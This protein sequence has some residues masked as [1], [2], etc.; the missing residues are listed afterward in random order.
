M[1]GGFGTAG[2][3]TAV[4]TTTTPRDSSQSPPQFF[5]MCH[6]QRSKLTFLPMAEGQN[7]L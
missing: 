3:G 5:F 1:A 6:G 2:S 7:L 4:A